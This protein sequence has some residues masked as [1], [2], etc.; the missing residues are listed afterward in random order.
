M[1]IFIGAM[2]G[3]FAGHVSAWI[4]GNFGRSLSQPARQRHGDRHGRLTHFDI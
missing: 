2:F 3:I 1:H 4:E